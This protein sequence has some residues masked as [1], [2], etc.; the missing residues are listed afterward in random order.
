MPVTIAQLRAFAAVVDHR[1][2]SVAAATL[3]VSQSAV[4]H[5]IS[6]LERE[7]SGSLFV[8]SA[9]V[10]PTALGT[11]LIQRA[12]TVLTAVDALEASVREHSGGHSGVVR[13]AAVPT[14]CQG[15]LPGLLQLWSARLP[16]VDV[17]VFEGDDEELPEWLASGLVDAAILVDPTERDK[18]SRFLASDDFR[19]LVRRDHPLAGQAEIPLVELLEDGLISSTGGCETQV[20]RIHELAGIRYTATQRV[21]ELATLLSLVRQGIGVGV[22]PSLGEAMLPA[23]L[24]L[25]PL[26]PKLHRELVLC[27]PAT[28]PWHPLTEALIDSLGRP[29]SGAE[30]RLDLLS[31]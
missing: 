26:S 15:L 31:V 16:R 20:R 29:S 17:Q 6:T 21:R 30:R 11:Q 4:S 3:G 9:G 24:I 19:A 27:G 13:L 14:V 2:F 7:I 1:S 25:V 23:E 5:A 8:R 12:R 18:R 10:A 28:R 22:M